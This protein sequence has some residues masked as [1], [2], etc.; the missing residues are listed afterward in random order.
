MYSLHK[1]S[2]ARKGS[3]WK[4]SMDIQLDFGID[5]VPYVDLYMEGFSYKDKKELDALDSAVNTFLESLEGSRR[6]AFYKRI[7]TL[8]KQ[9]RLGEE[10]LD[11]L[12]RFVV[13]GNLLAPALSAVTQID[14]EKN[15]IHFV[16]GPNTSKQ[17]LDIAWQ[18]SEEKRKDMFGTTKV[19]FAT[20]KA[21]K[22][23][24]ETSELIEGENSSEPGKN[25]QLDVIGRMYPA[26]ESNEE[27]FSTS[28]GAREDRKKADRLKKRKSR[29]KR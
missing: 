8:R 3:F 21:I 22:K 12:K 27:D 9:S 4:E 13:T 1:T 11:V 15:S 18:M 5:N 23:F 25:T 26:D 14:K 7:E 10:W 2:V 28:E 16:I 17:D 6:K 19:S 29:L 24:M 20:E